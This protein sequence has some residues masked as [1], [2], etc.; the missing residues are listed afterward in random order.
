MQAVKNIN[1]KN[2]NLYTNNYWPFSFNDEGLRLWSQ[3]AYR[4]WLRN[5]KD[6]QTRYVA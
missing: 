3:E 6:G 2:V 4:R 1:D 5:T